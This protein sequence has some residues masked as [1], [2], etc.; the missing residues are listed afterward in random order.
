MKEALCFLLLALLW[1]SHSH[2]QSKLSSITHDHEHAFEH[3]RHVYQATGLKICEVSDRGAIIWSRLTTIAEPIALGGKTPLINYHH[4][5]ASTLDI[6]EGK[7]RDNRTILAPLVRYPT[8]KEELHQL[9]GA[10]PGAMGQTR[11]RYRALGGMGEEDQPQR[12]WTYTS[13]LSTK[14]SRD[15]SVQ[16]TLSNLEPHMRYEVEVQ[17]RTLEGL[18]SPAV[19]S[20]RFHTAPDSVS[21]KPVHFV[22]MTCQVRPHHAT[23]PLCLLPIIT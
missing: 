12:D 20:G 16:H 2:S 15:F 13:W 7:F 6:K 14:K 22:L 23:N 9:Q 11:V 10:S 3:Q 1:I 21:E 5:N 4:V 17:G 18:V 8:S 19:E